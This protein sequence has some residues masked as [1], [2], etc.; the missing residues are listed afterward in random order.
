MSEKDKVYIAL[1]SFLKRQKEVY[2][3]HLN[4]KKGQ[5]YWIFRSINMQ[6]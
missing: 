6:K 1:S 2:Q 5:T 3:S 4:E